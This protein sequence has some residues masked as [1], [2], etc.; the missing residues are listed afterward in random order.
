MRRGLGKYLDAVAALG[1]RRVS[2]LFFIDNDDLDKL[3]MTPEER[4]WRTFILSVQRH[5]C[6][7]GCRWKHGKRVSDTFC[8][9]G[10][11]RRVWGVTTLK[12]ARSSGCCCT[13]SGTTSSCTPCSMRWTRPTTRPSCGGSS[14]GLS[15][16][17]VL[18]LRVI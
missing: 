16:Q 13:T 5:D 7:D 18:L 4:T 15:S 9:S 6:R 12:R 17:V 3:G 2:D 8:K 11:P 10:Y 14:C 1:A